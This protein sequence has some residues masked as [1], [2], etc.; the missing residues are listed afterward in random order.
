ML[1]Y[2]IGMMVATLVAMATSTSA[3]VASYVFFGSLAVW[4]LVGVG[5]IIGENTQK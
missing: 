2:F 4:V 1:G 5:I 3:E